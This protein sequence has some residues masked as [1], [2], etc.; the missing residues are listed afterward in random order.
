MTL[1]EL[2]R[3]NSIKAEI[4]TLKA[5]I[6]ELTSIKNKI[7]IKKLIGIPDNKS[8]KNLYC[9]DNIDSIKSMV[10]LWPD[11]IVA[12]IE[13]KFKKVRKLQEELELI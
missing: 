10:V 2:E 6:S 1:E 9:Y 3:A 7:S 11:E 8:Y 4:D 5:K 13:C 12:V